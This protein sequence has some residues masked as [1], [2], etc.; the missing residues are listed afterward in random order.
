[1]Q[2]DPTLLE[3]GLETTF[4]ILLRAG[5]QRT[6]A[7]A[8]QFCVH[9]VEETG[10]SILNLADYGVKTALVFSVLQL[11]ISIFAGLCYL[12]WFLTEAPIGPAI[13][14]ITDS[15]YFTTLVHSSTL[16][17]SETLCNAQPYVIW[18][19]LDIVVRIGETFRSRDEEIVGHITMDRPKFIAALTNGR[20]YN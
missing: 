2:V 5:A 11:A 12:P 13:R 14:L 20:K 1:M 16:Y 9:N 8:G 7:T 3:A 6:F 15:V 18:Q 17:N 10:V 19:A 4:A